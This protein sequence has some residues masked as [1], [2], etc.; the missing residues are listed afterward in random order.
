[1]RYVLGI[2]TNIGNR[3]EN[4]ERAIAAIETLPKT[5]VVLKSS[6]YE[7]QPVGYDEQDNFYNIC[8]EVQSIFNPFEMIG[9]VLGI[10]AGFGRVRTIKNGPRII[11]IDIIFV[12]NM[13]IQSPNLTVPHPRYK[14]RRFVL[15]PLMELYP[16]GRFMS[17]RFG[18][19]SE[20][21]EN[22]DVKK[23]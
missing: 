22:Q 21:I 5:R 16:D 9:A 13:V 20:K 7:T 17:Y 11:D 8:V 14:E 19:L 2:G 15:E 10:E 23:L 1:M 6:I 12:E 18:G 3:K 4:I